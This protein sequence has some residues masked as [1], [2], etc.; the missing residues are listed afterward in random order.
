MVQSKKYDKNFIYTLFYFPNSYSQRLIKYS[1]KNSEELCL[2]SNKN[3]KTKFNKKM[4]NLYTLLKKEKDIQLKNYKT[5][6]KKAYDVE[7][8]VASFTR[9][10][11]RHFTEKYK[12]E[13][14]V[15]NAFFK[16]WEIFHNFSFSFKKSKNH[17]VKS[18]H[19]AELPGQIINSTAFFTQ[20]IGKK[21]NWKAESLNPTHPNNIKKYGNQIFN[22]KYN[23][24]GRD[25]FLGDRWLKD[26][27]FYNKKEN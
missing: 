12:P 3:S 22:D 24:H 8:I 26:H 21:L 17:E 13:R 2:K 9:G 16:V 6:P 10:V 19:F 14:G 1:N 4:E 5:N 18:F 27:A 25:A 15:S 23:L 11:S 7:Q 20:S